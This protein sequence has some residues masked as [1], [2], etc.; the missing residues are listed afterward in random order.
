MNK[1]NNNEWMK[2][3][4]EEYEQLIN[5]DPLLETEKKEDLLEQL[6]KKTGKSREEILAMI[7]KM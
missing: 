1:D 3:L 7:E 2:K 5:S 6:Q 4:K